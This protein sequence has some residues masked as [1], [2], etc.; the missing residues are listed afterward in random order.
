MKYTKFR[1]YLRESEYDDLSPERRQEL[2]ELFLEL[3]DEEIDHLGQILF[4]YFS[5]EDEDEDEEEYP[6][7][8]FDVD[9]LN[10]L[11]N[12]IGSDSYA[13]I[14]TI[15]NSEAETL[16]DIFDEIDSIIEVDLTES[17]LEAIAKRMKVRNMN[18]A[19]KFMAVTR[20]K[21]R[22]G[23]AARRVLLRKTKHKRRAKYRK[24][25]RRIKAYQKSR[26]TAIKSGKHIVKRRR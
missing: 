1:E 7:A 9:D 5:D 6:E 14:D 21:L 17:I 10:A 2:D 19:R 18:R 13:A 26:A 22:A 3:T 12:A 11:I 16:E 23:K 20:A 15:L 4:S 25:K 24:N 8:E